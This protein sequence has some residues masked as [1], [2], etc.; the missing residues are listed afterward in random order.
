M[1][2]QPTGK[3]DNAA[4]PYAHITATP[5]AAAMGAEIRGVDLAKLT[6]AQAEEIKQ[7]LWRHKMIYFRDQTIGHAEQEAFT[8][9]FGPFGTDAYTTGMPGH[10]N[11]QPVVKDMMAAKVKQQLG[12]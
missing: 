10:P 9:R 11:V 7:A 8:L 6:D 5:L 3:F 4:R 12:G 2:L 1:R